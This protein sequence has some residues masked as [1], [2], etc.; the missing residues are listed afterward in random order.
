M[1]CRSSVRT[2]PFLI[3]ILCRP[4]TCWQK[5]HP[6]QQKRRVRCSETFSSRTASAASS[7]W[8][9]LVPYISPHG[10]RQEQEDHPLVVSR[11]PAENQNTRSGSPNLRPQCREPKD[12][13]RHQGEV[14]QA[15]TGYDSGGIDV[16]KTLDWQSAG[17]E[18]DDY[19]PPPW[20]RL[21][22]ERDLYF[23]VRLEQLL[24]RANVK[25]Q[26]RR[27]KGSTTSSRPRRMEPGLKRKSGCC[28][29][30]AWWNRP[31]PQANLARRGDGLSNF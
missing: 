21:R 19:A 27:G 9:F 7:N 2:A 16:F 28:E 31:D 22:L 25:G 26:L 15:M 24:R 17:T 23:S 4:H 29:N 13:P 18:E 30:T 6:R 20:T 1:H 12:W 5:A 14:W 11:S 8:P 10:Q 3:W